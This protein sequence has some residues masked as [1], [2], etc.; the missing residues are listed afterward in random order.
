M[1]VPG[2]R[3]AR[4]NAQ[5]SDR[6]GRPTATAYLP[7]VNHRMWNKRR[8]ALLARCL[9][10][11]ECKLSRTHIHRLSA[12]YAGRLLQHHTECRIRS[13]RLAAS[14][15]MSVDRCSHADEFQL[16]VLAASYCLIRTA[17]CGLSYSCSYL[18]LARPAELQVTS[19]PTHNRHGGES[20]DGR[21]LPWLSCP[22]LSRT[23]WQDV[24]SPQTEDRHMLSQHSP[25]PRCF[26]GSRAEVLLI[27]GI[28][29]P[30]GTLC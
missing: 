24:S 8:L 19:V 22:P 16:H 28:P 10:A 7:C 21:T 15:F 1:R 2:M 27:R 20:R 12:V 3:D 29:Y 18:H 9:T 11:R 23:P 6:S 13:P 26:G 17:R 4:R 25:P 14:C 5:A 30:R